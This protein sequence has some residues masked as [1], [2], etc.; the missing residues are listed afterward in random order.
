MKITR[1]YKPLTTLA[2]I[3]MF[4]QAFSQ[5]YTEQY[6]LN[7]STLLNFSLSAV[8][9]Q[10][11]KVKIEQAGNE[12]KKTE[13]TLTQFK[14]TD[15]TSVFIYKIES[16]FPESFVDSQEKDRQKTILQEQAKLLFF[17]YGLE[18]LLFDEEDAPVIGTLKVN[19]L[20]NLYKGN[21]VSKEYPIGTVT[22]ENVEIEFLDGFIE[23]ILV[24]GKGT[25]TG[26][27]DEFSLFFEN[28]FGIGFSTRRNYQRL[29]KVALFDV[30]NA[31]TNYNIKLGQLINYTYKVRSENK[32][33]SPKNGVVYT[34]GGKSIALKKEENNKLFSFIVYSDFM[35]FDG[36][37]PN[38]LV[39]T[40]F[41][42]LISLNTNRFQTPP[43][44]INIISKG[45]GF[46]QYIQPIFRLSKIE[47][48]NK[49][50]IPERIASNTAQI[51]DSSNF[52]NL[53][54]SPLN[55]FNYQRLS[56]GIN[57]N[58]LF[59]DNPEMKY[60]AQL[61]FA[62][63][64]GRTYIQD[65]ILSKNELGQFEN[66]GRTDEFGINYFALGPNVNVKFFPDER[67]GLFL[68]WQPRYFVHAFSNPA[69]TTYKEDGQSEENY[70][71]WMNTYEIEG[72]WRPSA[73]NGKVF[74]R[75]RF[76]NQWGNLTH[77][78]HQL[79]TGLS[80]FITSSNVSK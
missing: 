63:N 47:D 71:K 2:I 73:V 42:K 35:G 39:Q 26:K 30:L 56:L 40:E 16:L 14:L 5:E 33:Y 80:F 37:K 60:H 58:L 38:G 28:K 74:V 52:S 10:G 17:N 57:L 31:D 25:L 21:N 23:T 65:S 7:D 41:T 51:S 45:H 4:G 55:I 66:T 64:F 15:F 54:T 32:D 46:I 78:F 27:N 50:L 13:F 61:D 48:N 6:K 19:N 24:S 8:E 59:L 49:Y 79:Q 1:F 75:W 12:A 34:Y 11:T 70:S 72:F 44:G 77:N 29:S 68:S 62:M 76:N 18:K 36:E 67:F 9:P 3:L 53:S 20:I 22:I 43:R 69:L